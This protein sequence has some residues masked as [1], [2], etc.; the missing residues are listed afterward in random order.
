MAVAFMAA[1]L[2]IGV[3]D[4]VMTVVLVTSMLLAL[5]TIGLLTFGPGPRAS[6]Q[7]DRQPLRFEPVLLISSLMV[8]ALG[9]AAIV[10]R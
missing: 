6:D 3:P 9:I 1:P 7:P 4:W 8:I 2:A 5:L 10:L